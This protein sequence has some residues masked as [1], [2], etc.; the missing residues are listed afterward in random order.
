M[1][2]I[3]R[4][5]RFSGEPEII[6]LKGYCG[7]ERPNDIQDRRFSERPVAK[8]GP[9]ERGGEEIRLQSPVAL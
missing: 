3:N 5:S 7:H 4:C 6:V 9:L 2:E 8:R 1:I